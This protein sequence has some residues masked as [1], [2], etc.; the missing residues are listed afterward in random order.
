MFTYR[1]ATPLRLTRQCDGN[2]AT[3]STHLKFSGYETTYSLMVYY[4]IYV[5]HELTYVNQF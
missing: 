1:V 4:T 3:I 2:E 5:G